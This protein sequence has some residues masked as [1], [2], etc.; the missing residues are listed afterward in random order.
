M[1]VFWLK[2]LSIFTVPEWNTYPFSPQLPHQRRLSGTTVQIIQPVS[3]IK[4]R[5]SGAIASCHKE[6]LTCSSLQSQ[7]HVEQAIWAV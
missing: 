4:D 5:L 2:I 6:L 7:E 1:W 3:T